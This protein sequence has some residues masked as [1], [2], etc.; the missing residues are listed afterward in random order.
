MK[1]LFAFVLSIAAAGCAGTPTAAQREGPAVNPNPVAALVGPAGAK[2]EIGGRY[3][4][5]TNLRIIRG[6]QIDYE[7]WLT[8]EYLPIGT[9]VTVMET[10]KSDTRWHVK[11]ADGREYWIIVGYGGGYRE[12]YQEIQKFLAA[13]DPKQGLDAGAGEVAD[14]I[15]FARPA[16][17]MTRAQA[18]AALGYPPNITDPVNSSRWTYPQLGAGDWR[19]YGWGRVGNRHTV[20]LEFDGDVVARVIGYESQ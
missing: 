9:E 10:A 1:K 16:V 14:G 4:T 20:A 11:T 15:K 8:G 5:R 3:W 7:T 2:V 18:I 19:A 12:P 17:G 13:S 6:A